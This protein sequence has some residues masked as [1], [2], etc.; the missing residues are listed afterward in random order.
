MPA[1]TDGH[2]LCPAHH[3]RIV[4][5]PEAT[6]SAGRMTPRLLG[7]LVLVCALFHGIAAWLGSDRGQWGLVVAAF[8][9][10][11]TAMYERFVLAPKTR[12]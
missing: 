3:V 5:G 10:A 11:A 2:K 12:T 8:V 6:E 4:G 7:G 9:V 1:T